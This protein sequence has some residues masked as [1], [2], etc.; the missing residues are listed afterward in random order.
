MNFLTLCTIVASGLYLWSG[1]NILRSMREG[2]EAPSWLRW[3]VIIGVILQ[4]LALH[5][6]MF[7]GEKIFIGF[8]Y[9]AAEV[10]FLA[11]LIFV[12]ETWIHRLHAQFGIMLVI[13]SVAALLPLLFPGTDLS[14]MATDMTHFSLLFRL[15][16]LVAIAAYSFLFIAFIQAVLLTLLNRQ[17]KAPMGQESENRFLNSLPGLVVMERIFFRIVSVGFAFIT[18]TLIIGAFATQ[19]HYHVWVHFDHKTILTWLAWIVFGILLLGRT[20]AG[21]RAKKALGW[22]W[23]GFAIFVLAYFGY[24]MVIELFQLR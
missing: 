11:I 7:R 15:H 9:V 4:A 18:L 2:T 12:I 5:A 1:I 6:E 14:K 23:A 8:G 24:S 21:W 22:F 10:C 16:L 3:P 20:I 17:L 13:L 19:E